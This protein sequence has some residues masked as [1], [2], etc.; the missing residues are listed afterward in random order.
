MKPTIILMLLL[1]FYQ[2]YAQSSHTINVKID[3]EDNCETLS[4]ESNEP[5][6]FQI[7]P[8]PVKT[9]INIESPNT[10]KEI[11]VY[12]VIGQEVMKRRVI[13]DVTVVDVRNIQSGIYTLQIKT[14]IEVYNHKI[15]IRHD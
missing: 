4:I 6:S 15:I 13:N 9:H 8:N 7:Y 12:N 14:D 1:S 3:Q 5:N 2:N 10:I 11:I